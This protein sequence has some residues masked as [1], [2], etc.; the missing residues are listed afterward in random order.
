MFRNLAYGRAIDS[1]DVLIVEENIAMQK[2]LTAVLRA[3]GVGRVRA[4]GSA[5][6]ALQDMVSMLPDILVT[7]WEMESSDAETMIRTMRNPAMHPMCFVPVIVL[8]ANSSRM[9]VEQTLEAGAS[10]IL[11]KPVSTKDLLGRIRWILQDARPFE[12]S[13]QI[14]AQPRPALPVALEQIVANKALI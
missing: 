1:L 4:M 8:T 2:I 13:G 9:V 14:Y 7:E 10:T 5:E 12:L 3:N 6:D 11:R